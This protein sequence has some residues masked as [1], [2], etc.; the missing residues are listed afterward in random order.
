MHCVPAALKRKPTN[1][2]CLVLTDG[3][4]CRYLHDEEFCRKSVL[5]SL[6]TSLHWAN[7]F[8]CPQLATAEDLD[9]IIGVNLRGTFLCYKYA[10]LQMIA[11]GRG[12]RIIGLPSVFLP[13]TYNSLCPGTFSNRR[14]LWH[15]KTGT[16][17]SERLLCEQIRYPSVDSVRW[18]V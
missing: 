16:S 1:A 11:Q 13:H 17:I 9:R 6:P 10:G 2:R 12:G 3:C 4:K 14:V 15:W 8:F 5:Q 18:C 7:F